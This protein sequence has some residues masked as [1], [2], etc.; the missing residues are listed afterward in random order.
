MVPET[1]EAFKDTLVKATPSVDWPPALQSIWWAA[2][3]D[4]NASHDIAQDL[5]TKI[6]SRIHAYLHRLEGDDWNAGYWYRQANES[7]PK[8][9]FEEELQKLMEFVLER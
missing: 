8:C 2:K 4:W 6:G 7:F 3:G 5:H 9:N 1:L